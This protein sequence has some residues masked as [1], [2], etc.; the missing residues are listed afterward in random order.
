MTKKNENGRERRVFFPTCFEVKDRKS[1]RS[2]LAAEDRTILFFFLLD[3]PDS[4]PRE[5]VP[6]GFGIEKQKSGGTRSEHE[7]DMKGSRLVQRSTMISSRKD[8]FSTFCL[9]V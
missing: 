9:I 1:E 5:F 7:G 8:L 4:K 2:I 6:L 3:F